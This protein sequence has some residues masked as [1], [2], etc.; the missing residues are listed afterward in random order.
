MR[1]MKRVLFSGRLHRMYLPFIILTLFSSIISFALHQHFKLKLPFLEFSWQISLGIFAGLFVGYMV[2]S[3]EG[4]NQTRYL[5]SILSF[6]KIEEP[7]QVV[8][9]NLSND[10]DLV[11]IPDIVNEKKE[12]ST[13]YSK[14]GPGEVMSIGLLYSAYSTLFSSSSSTINS[15]NISVRLSSKDFNNINFRSQRIVLGGPKFN[16]VTRT[17]LAKKEMNINYE[18]IDKQ[19]VLHFK[20]RKEEMTWNFIN[21]ENDQAED[22]GL[23]VKIKRNVFASGIKTWGV[24]ASSLCL[25][26]EA[27]AKLL[28]EK[29]EEHKIDPMKNDYFAVVKC[30]V[31]NIHEEY[32]IGEVTICMVHL[33][34][35]SVS[36]S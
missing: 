34:P 32:S 28:V 1:K 3:V 5:S 14:T 4:F 9:A 27:N 33:I 31:P 7:L 19:H 36:R 15:S 30:A 25:F 17:L 35:E 22:H 6:I 24:I 18:L 23:I 21:N 12:N 16:E 13:H 10:H 26:S 29:L 2:D 11:P 8:I 20:D